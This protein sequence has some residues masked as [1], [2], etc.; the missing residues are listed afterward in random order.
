MKMVRAASQSRYK[1]AI[2]YSVTG[3]L[4]VYSLKRNLALIEHDS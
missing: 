3:K 4:M 1:A 2:R